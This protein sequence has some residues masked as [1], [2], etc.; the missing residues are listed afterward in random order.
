MGREVRRV[1]IDFDWPM[2]KVW[3]GFLIPEDLCTGKCE[4]CDGSG[5]TNA[6]RAV[7][8]TANLL[9]MLDNDRTDQARGRQLH[10]YF[11]SFFYGPRPSADIAEFGE[12]LAG[13]AGGFGGHDAIDRWNALE[14]IIEA[15][16]LDP[17]VWGICARCEGHGDVEKYVGQRAAAEAW[18]PTDPPKGDGWQYWETV[19]EGSP[20]SPVFAT[21]EELSLWLQTDYSWGANHGPLTKEQADN[22]VRVGWAPSGIVDSTGFHT[23]DTAIPSEQEVK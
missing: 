3:Q 5:S 10:P 7:E 8:Q 11:S 13:R 9:L 4:A 14:K 6:R 12:G 16:G 1:P 23:G 19:S 21:A 2:G 20:I 22:M 17:R 15:A 18:E